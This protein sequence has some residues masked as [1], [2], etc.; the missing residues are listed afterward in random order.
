MF[1]LP[2]LAVNSALFNALTQRRAG[3]SAG[4]THVRAGDVRT[5]VRTWGTTGPAVVLVPG[6]FETADTFE[7][8]GE[9][10][11]T[12]HRVYARTFPF[13][14][15]ARSLVADPFRTSILRIGLSSD[16]LVRGVYD[17]QCGPL[18]PELT[19]SDVDR[20]RRPLRQPGS[21]AAMWQTMETGIPTLTAAQT[22]E[23]RDSSMATAVA[24]GVAD[25]QFS[26]STA[27]DVAERI[28][29]PPPTFL[30]GRH[31][32][33]ISAPAALAEAIR[34]LGRRA[35]PVSSPTA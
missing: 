19:D 3:P 7:S 10:L 29:A 31:L 28:G 6:A 12:D 15:L 34:D 4:L 2:V 22:D 35:G 26:R 27:H 17:T 16:R 18:C 20:W 14:G 30:P 23:L 25:P 11:A 13:P 9:Q 21:E 1:A 24:G 8:L 32:P 5:R 33:M